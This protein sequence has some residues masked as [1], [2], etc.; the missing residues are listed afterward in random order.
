MFGHALRLLIGLLK[1]SVQ[2]FMGNGIG[3]FHIPHKGIHVFL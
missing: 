1:C 3:E 2:G